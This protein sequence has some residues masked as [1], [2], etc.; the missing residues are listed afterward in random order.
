MPRRTQARQRGSQAMMELCPRPINKPAGTKTSQDCGLSAAQKH[1]SQVS[2]QALLACLSKWDSETDVSPE[3]PS[4]SGFLVLTTTKAEA[5]KPFNGT[6]PL[7]AMACLRSSSLIFGDRPPISIGG[8]G[9]DGS[10]VRFRVIRV[11]DLLFE[12]RAV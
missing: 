12:V 1:P 5:Y 4:R 9:F 6:P 7:G 10:G 11:W 3:K 2:W 8:I